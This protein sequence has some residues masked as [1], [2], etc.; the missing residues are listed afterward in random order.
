[1]NMKIHFSHK[2]ESFIGSV[3]LF[4]TPSWKVRGLLQTAKAKGELVA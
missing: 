1:M 4:V 3:L 2:D